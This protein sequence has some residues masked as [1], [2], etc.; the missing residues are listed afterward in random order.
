ME[1]KGKRSK[2][3]IKPYQQLRFGITFLILN[4]I[5]T[6]LM[7]GVFAYYMW[8]MFQAIQAFFQLSNAES[9]MSLQKFM[10]PMILSLILAVV[11]IATT[12]YCSARYTHQIYGPLVSIKRFLDAIIAGNN[13]EHIRIRKTDQLHTL[14]KRLNVIADKFV[15]PSSKETMD[16]VLKYVDDLNDGKSPEKLSI[17]EDDVLYELS[18]KLNQLSR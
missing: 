11:F 4:F 15:Y 1:K 13:P 3:L 16:Q 5:F 9:M 18:V 7:L 8:D 12:L 14:V 10:K 6:C 17:S 2:I